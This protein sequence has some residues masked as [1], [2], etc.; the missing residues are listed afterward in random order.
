MTRIEPLSNVSDCN[1]DAAEV[2]PVDEDAV[3][4]DPVEVDVLVVFELVLVGWFTC[5]FTS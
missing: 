2:D 1:E 4:A 5:V 3:E